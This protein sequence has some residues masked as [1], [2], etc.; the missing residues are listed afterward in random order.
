MLMK[1]SKA[2]VT[3]VTATIT[4]I[5]PPVLHALYFAAIF[6]EQNRSTVIISTVNWETKHTV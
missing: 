3:H 4:N 5:F 2:G 6:T 1:N